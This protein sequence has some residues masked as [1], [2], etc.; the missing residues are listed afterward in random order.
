MGWNV[1]N[2]PSEITPYHIK[3]NKGLDDIDKREVDR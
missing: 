2:Q 3:A 1:V